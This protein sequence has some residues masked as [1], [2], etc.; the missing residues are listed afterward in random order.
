MPTGHP[1]CQEFFTVARVTLLIFAS[2]GRGPVGDGL[3]G[4]G[5][6]IGVAPMTAGVVT[7]AAGGDAVAGL[8]PP[9]QADESVTDSPVARI[10]RVTRF[11][12][13]GLHDRS[14]ASATSMRDDEAATSGKQRT[15][16]G[17][18]GPKAPAAPRY[19]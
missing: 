6:G 19:A 2:N 11:I 9:P 5:E 17:G 18:D 15:D 8:P 16:H 10:P 4:D 12:A 1:G 14:R 13:E 3:D 7:A